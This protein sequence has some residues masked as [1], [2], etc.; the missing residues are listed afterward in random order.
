VTVEILGEK[1]VL[2]SDA[3]PEYTRAVAAHVEAKV[4]ALPGTLENHRRAIL[5]ALA[6]TD[7]LFRAREEIRLLQESRERGIS[8]LAER[9]ERA[10]RDT[11]TEPES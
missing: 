1:H 4:A 9:M 3:A 7:E 11:E 8:A 10:L 2:R 5:A 6:I